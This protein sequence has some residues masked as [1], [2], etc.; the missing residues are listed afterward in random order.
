MLTALRSGEYIGTRT[1]S[2]PLEKVVN[3]YQVIG[4]IAAS[5]MAFG[6]IV[7]T[8]VWIGLSMLVAFLAV[9]VVTLWFMIGMQKRAQQSLA[10]REQRRS[11]LMRHYVGMDNFYSDEVPSNTTA[12]STPASTPAS[13]SGE[14]SSPLVGAHLAS[15]TEHL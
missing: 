1:H 7:A 14:H 11:P 9:Y 15:A 12:A 5:I 10:Y 6:V 2:G 8:L 13:N 4:I 3:P